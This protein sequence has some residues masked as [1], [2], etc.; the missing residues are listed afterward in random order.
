MT[1]ARLTSSLTSLTATCSSF[2][3]ASFDP[4]PQYAMAIVYMPDRRKMASCKKT[5]LIFH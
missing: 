1:A 4:V 3:M 2:L 5:F